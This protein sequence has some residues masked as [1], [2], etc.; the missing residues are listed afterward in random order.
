MFK[1]RVELQVCYG[2]MSST[3]HNVVTRHGADF[4]AGGGKHPPWEFAGGLSVRDA[5][6]PCLF[7]AVSRG[8]VAAASIRDFLV[9]I[10]FKD[11]P[12]P[13]QGEAAASK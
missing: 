13:P 8:G 1:P 3:T 5:K 7:D 4:Y 9:G 12:T 6:A 11:I 10:G 2:G